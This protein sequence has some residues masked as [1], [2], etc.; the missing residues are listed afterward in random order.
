MLENIE[1]IYINLNDNI[2]EGMRYK[3]L[4]IYSV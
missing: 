3:E 1:V 4:L 2:I